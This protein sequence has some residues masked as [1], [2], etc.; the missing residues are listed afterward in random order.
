MCIFEYRI[1]DCS[2]FQPSAARWDYDGMCLNPNGDDAISLP[3]AAA[4][5]VHLGDTKPNL[6][7]V[8]KIVVTWKIAELVTIIIMKPR[9]FNCIEYLLIENGHWE[10]C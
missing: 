5:V 1:L 4:A 7:K 10:K 2:F 8:L 9:F 6:S 3:K